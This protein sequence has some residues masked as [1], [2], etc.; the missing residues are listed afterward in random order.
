MYDPSQAQKLVLNT[1]IDV[2]DPYLHTGTLYHS[3]QVVEPG[4]QLCS[5]VEVT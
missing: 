5:V 3:A 2:P 4:S 1:Q